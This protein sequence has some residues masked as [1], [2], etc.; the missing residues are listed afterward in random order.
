MYAKLKKLKM[1]YIKNKNSS[2]PSL[3]FPHKIKT[4]KKIVT[5][6]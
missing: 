3:Y 6:M 2:S 4:L 1:S 5:E